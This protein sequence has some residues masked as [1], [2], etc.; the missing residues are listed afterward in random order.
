VTGAA[1]EGT[2]ALSGAHRSG[3]CGNRSGHLAS[4]AAQPAFADPPL[5]SRRS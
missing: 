1:G 2:T 3:R 5:R 4:T